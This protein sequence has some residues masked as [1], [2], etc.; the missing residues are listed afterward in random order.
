[1]KDTEHFGETFKKGEDDNLGDDLEK[2][3]AKLLP[4]FERMIFNRT[5]KRVNFLL[6]RINDQK[7][8]IVADGNSDK[9]EDGNWRLFIDSSGDLIIQKR[10]SGTWTNYLLQSGD[11]NGQMLF[12]DGVK[13]AK[14]ETSELFWDDAEKAL[15]INQPNPASGSKLDVGGTVVVTRIL[16]G[17]VQP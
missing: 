5:S 17:G 16:A 2:F 10:V 12:W 8:E 15:G 6:T 7:L 1:M 13:W 4:F 14:T 11:A 9:D 3:F